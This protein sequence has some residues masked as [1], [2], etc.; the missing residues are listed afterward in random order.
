MEHLGRFSAEGATTEGGFGKSVISLRDYDGPPPAETRG[1]LRSR[2]IG[3]SP[4]GSRSDP[5]TVALPRSLVG[6]L[7]RSSPPRELVRAPYDG[8]LRSGPPGGAHN[9]RLWAF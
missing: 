6:L 3:D 5:S 4:D 1:L 9:H 7:L 2:R 8:S